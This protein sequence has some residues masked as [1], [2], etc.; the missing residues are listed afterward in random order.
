MGSS[1]RFSLSQVSSH[2][3]AKDCW[4]IIHGKV[5][6]VSKFLEEHPGG[7]E[8]LLQSAAKGD[9]TEDFDEVGHTTAATA[10][11]TCYYLGDLKDSD[12]NSDDGAAEEEKYERFVPPKASHQ[13][14][15]VFMK[16]IPFLIL[17]MA[18][19]VWDYINKA[20]A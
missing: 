16:L 8:V 10:M 3:S 5:Y 6:D 14:S 12:S 9:A 20:K 13:S 15:L 19:A 4:V 7:E 18:F 17:V 1:K 2:T 11:M